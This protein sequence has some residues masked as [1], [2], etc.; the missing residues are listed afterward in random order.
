[1]MIVCISQIPIQS[2]ST[3]DS[4]R[5]VLRNKGK[6]HSV[7]S[8]AV[9]QNPVPQ[10]PFAFRAGF[11]C[12]ALAGAVTNRSRDLNPVQVKF[13]KSES[14]QQDGGYSGYSAPRQTAP[15]PV[16]KIGYPVR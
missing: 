15:N 10:D 11:L 4:E 1:M 5:Q 8:S 6:H 14:C 12:D 2:N 13:S 7:M 16:S 9:Y 3:I